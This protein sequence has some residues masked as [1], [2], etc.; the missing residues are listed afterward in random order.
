[1]PIQ[2]HRMNGKIPGAKNLDQPECDGMFFS[3]SIEPTATCGSAYIAYVCSPNNVCDEYIGIAE[4]LTSHCIRGPW[5]F[6]LLCLLRQML[7]MNA[8][9]RKLLGL[10]PPEAYCI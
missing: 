9:D 7:A 10:D 4:E 2:A 3:G 8:N 6:H 5:F 1:M